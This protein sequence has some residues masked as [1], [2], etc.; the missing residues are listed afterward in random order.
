MVSATVALAMPARLTMSPAS[1]LVDRRARQAAEGEDLR[2]AEALDLGAVAGER[3][4]RLAGA[5]RAALDPPGQQPAEEGVGGERRRQHREGL[6]GAGEL[7]RRRARGRGSAGRARR[8][9][10]RGPSSSASAQPARPEA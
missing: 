5:D 9:L 2:D 8:G 7:R 6:V 1:A 4:Q 10:V 3:L